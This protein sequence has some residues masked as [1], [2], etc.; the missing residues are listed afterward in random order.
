MQG[1]SDNGQLIG[2][3]KTLELAY[4]CADQF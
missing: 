4:G 1:C 2:R 3:A